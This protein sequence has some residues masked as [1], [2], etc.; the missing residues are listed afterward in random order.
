MGERPPGPMCITK[1]GVDW[2]DQGTMCRSRSSPPVSTGLRCGHMSAQDKIGEAIQRSVPM[3]PAEARYQVQAMLSPK[4]LAIVAGT[5]TVWA[6][7]HFFGVGEIIDIILLV[8]GFAVLGFSVFNGAQELYNFATTAVKA[9]TQADLDRAAHHFA[10]AV[11]IL[12]IS[13]ISAVLLRRGMRASG[14]GSGALRTPPRIRESTGASPRG[15][16]FQSASAQTTP[17]IN[18]AIRADVAESQGYIAALRGGEIGLQRSQGANV[19]GTD[20]ITAAPNAQGVMEVIVTDV[21]MST[22]GRFP[23]PRSTV[24]PEWVAEVRAAVAPGRLNLNDPTLEQQI[25]AAVAAGR[26][27][28]R[29][30]N[31]DYS[32]AGQG[33]ITGF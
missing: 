18:T 13:V 17:S 8:A 22:T 6:G 11:N 1:L 2:I 28:S 33:R 16:T 30:L 9:Q 25:R 31:A 32:P 3:L 7:S 14:T 24:P 5:L 29:Q 20:F 15:S 26:I 19:R 23:T 4:S 10:S 27:R 12:G 21:K